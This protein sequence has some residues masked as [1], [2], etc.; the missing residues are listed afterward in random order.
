MRNQ[1]IADMVCRAIGH[2]L[3]TG[4]HAIGPTLYCTRCQT[5]QW[6]VHECGFIIKADATADDLKKLGVIL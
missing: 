6:Y 5:I 2:R 1:R 4:W 3:E